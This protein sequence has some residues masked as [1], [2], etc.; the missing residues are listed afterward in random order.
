MG[1][2]VTKNESGIP[3]MPNPPPPPPEDQRRTESRQLD[4]EL[5]TAIKGVLKKRKQAGNSP[6]DELIAVL[7]IDFASNRIWKHLYDQKAEETT[8][9]DK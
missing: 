9:G 1:E 2:G 7:L 3:D 4:L 8:A 5:R 6:P